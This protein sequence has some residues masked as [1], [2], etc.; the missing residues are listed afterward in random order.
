MINFKAPRNMYAFLIKEEDEE[1]NNSVY[2][3]ETKTL[4]ICPD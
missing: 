4:V 1:A 3:E 2:L